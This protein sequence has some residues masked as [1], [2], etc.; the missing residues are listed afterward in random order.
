MKLKKYSDHKIIR[1][2]IVKNDEVILTIEE[3]NNILKEIEY[4]KKTIEELQDELDTIESEKIKKVEYKTVKFDINDYVSDR[5][6][7][8][9][10]KKIKK[11]SNSYTG[12]NS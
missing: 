4:Y 9:R 11:S 10:S 1:R 6:H 7:K 3:Y 2:E 8:I 12:E 5:D